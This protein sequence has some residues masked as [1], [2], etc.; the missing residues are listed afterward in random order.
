MLE[1]TSG[2]FLEN[3]DL[4]KEGKKTCLYM[5]VLII[6]YVIKNGDIEWRS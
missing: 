5:P 3:L 6:W 2:V 1:L 4:K